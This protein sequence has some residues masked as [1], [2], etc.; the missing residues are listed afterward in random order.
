MVKLA[1]EKLTKSLEVEQGEECDP[2]IVTFVKISYE[3]RIIDT[4]NSKRRIPTKNNNRM[5]TK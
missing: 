5:V 2:R 1:K 4:H 3:R